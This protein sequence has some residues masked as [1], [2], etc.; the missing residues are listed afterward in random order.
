MECHLQCLSDTVQRLLELTSPA[1]VIQDDEGY[2]SSDE[3]DEWV[4]AP[5]ELPGE[6]SSEDSWDSDEGAQIGDREDG[7]AEDGDVV[8]TEDDDDL[9]DDVSEDDTN[10]P[11]AEIPTATTVAS[12]SP[13]DQNQGV[14]VVSNA[15]SNT[16]FTSSWYIRKRTMLLQRRKLRLTTL[17]G[18]E[19]HLREVNDHMAAID[20]VRVNMK[21]LIKLVLVRANS[22]RQRTTEH[23]LTEIGGLEKL[24]PAELL[25]TIFTFAQEEDQRMG[26]S[27]SHVSVYF[28]SVALKTPRLWTVINLSRKLSFIKLSLSRAGALPLNVTISP[29]PYAR[30]SKKNKE[31]INAAL[32][33][34]KRNGN[35]WRS[36]SVVAYRQKWLQFIAHSLVNITQGEHPKLDF[37]EV[38]VGHVQ[39]WGAMA[40][41]FPPLQ[42]RY[43]LLD[44]VCALDMQSW[45]SSRLRVLHLNHL[46]ANTT[47]SSLLQTLHT[48]PDLEILQFT[49]TRFEV[50]TAIGPL[51]PLRLLHL[52]SLTFFNCGMWV[53][54]FMSGT[55]LPRMRRLS[56]DVVGIVYKTLQLQP[57]ISP[58]EEL[59]LET[60]ALSDALV[61]EMD[62]ETLA[63]LPR[64]W[65]MLFS[66][67]PCLT[68]FRI[69]TLEPAEDVLE[70]LNIPPSITSGSEVLCPS[71]HTL[72]FQDTYTVPSPLVE[73]VILSRMNVP[74]VS[75]IRT[76]IV[77]RCDNEFMDY[78]ALRSLAL[79]EKGSVTTLEL[80]SLDLSCAVVAMEEEAARSVFGSDDEGS[81]CELGSGDELAA[82][83]TEHDFWPSW[84]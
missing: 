5:E 43:A 36:L 68:T 13:G 38:Q 24:L 52:E 23:S 71:L 45:F 65:P 19:G 32:Q 25:G 9:E 57:K 33:V 72:E 35:G 42:P 28:R 84:N 37:L 59:I 1:E 7:I 22:L 61:E 46:E 70:P 34:I 11:A 41:D 60:H 77:R 76:L 75:P 73:K 67:L 48:T 44:G 31:R 74:G 20:Q 21:K 6:E 56:L 63:L 82:L 10:G 66:L 55:E 51:L 2:F 18:L 30:Y 49:H 54:S 27:L 26:M 39:E 3:E 80:E 14:D 12:V 29:H 53:T 40:V 15:E 62:E 8:T 17:S 81:E 69:T 79:A 78:D 64:R 50:T 47:F 16:S 58:I 4:G 83:R